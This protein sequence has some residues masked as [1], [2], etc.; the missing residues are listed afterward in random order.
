M[1]K[2]FLPITSEEAAARGWNSLDVIIVTGDAYVD[3]PSYG[4]AV[5]GRVLEAEGFRIG[6]IPQPDWRSLKDFKSLGRPR[7]FFGVTAGN[8]DSMLANYTSNRNRRRE[9]EYS[10]G[11]KTGLRPDRATIIYTNRIKEAFPGTPVV[12]GGVEA[13]LR[14]LAHYDYWSDKVRKS[15]LLDSKADILVFGMGERQLIEIARRLNGGEDIKRLDNIKGT[16]IARSSLGGI[17]GHILVPSFEDVSQDKDKFNTAFMTIYE[18]SD[19]K[20]GRTIVQP[21]GERFVIELP[22]AAPLTTPEMDSIYGLDYARAPHPRY[23]KE[24][25]VPGFEAVRFSIISHRGCVGACNFCSLYL[26]QGRIVQSRSPDS[27]VEEAGI[28]SNRPDFKGTIT[29]IGG[30]TANIFMADC[31]E[32]GARGACRAKQCL[33]PAKCKNLKIDYDDTVRLWERVRGLPRVKH[34]FIGS[35]LRFDLLLD[36]SAGKYLRE[37]C[38]YHISGRLKVAP[39]HTEDHVLKLM[40]KP[41][42]RRYE[43][44]ASKFDMVNREVGKK[45]FLVN[46]IISGHPGC[47]LEDSLDLS[48][49][50]AKKHI[51][52]EQIQDFIPL[53]MTISS[54]IYH[55]GKDPLTGK[56]VYVAKG[57]R[58]RKL[59]RAL[60]QYDNPENRRY[61]IEALKKLG[62]MDLAKIFLAKRRKYEGW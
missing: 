5:L 19:P 23:G 30:P 22:P 52:P 32:W 35:G 42:F 16:V 40:N 62:R 54:S 11:G 4:A 49:G 12:I 25:G 20:H 28:L 53:P 41:S 17:G 18:E 38:R 58:E 43:E 33:M 37:L 15:I 27:I 51:H 44:F 31:K 46:Y 48:L 26:H 47:T 9:D 2:K 21:H 8:L 61:V 57:L 50:L 3:H 36:N 56:D 29:D 6:I 7:L 60:I 59:Q 55:T 45:Q 13:S 10:P 1:N 14:R 24:G 39:E 34:L